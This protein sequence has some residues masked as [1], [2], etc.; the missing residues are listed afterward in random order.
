MGAGGGANRAAGK[1][2][3]VA[4][5][6]LV[7]GA[8]HGAW[9]F[10][11]LVPALAAR[12]HRAVAIDLPGQGDDLTPP[13]DCTLDGN[14]R[15]IVAALAAEPGPAVL[16]GHS[17]GGVSIAAAAEM[18]PERVR[19]LVFLCAFLLPDG[20]SAVTVS[21]WPEAGRSD[22]PPAFVRAADGLSVSVVPE[23]AAGLFYS[24]CDPADIA[25]ALQRLRPQPRAIQTTAVRLTPERYGSV[26]RAYV[27][28]RADRTIPIGLQCAMVAASPCDPVLSLPGGH[29]PFLSVPD[30]LAEV[31]AGLA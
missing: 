20:E 23:R 15:R 18:A 26:P 31:L 4:T 5:F 8:F 22:G 2:G 25:D 30:A 28:C 19:R 3:R 13:G 24:D 29:S 27:E 1:R 16:V 14:A 10:A 6:I 17:L 7:H 11:K 9:C 21:R 12:G